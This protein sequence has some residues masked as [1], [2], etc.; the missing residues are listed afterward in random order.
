M[1]I[2]IHLMSVHIIC[3]S[4]GLVSICPHVWTFYIIMDFFFRAKICSWRS[5]SADGEYVLQWASRWLDNG[6]VTS[7]VLR[8]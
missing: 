6:N 4:N 5:Y 8:H 7:S 2:V 3:K 1:K